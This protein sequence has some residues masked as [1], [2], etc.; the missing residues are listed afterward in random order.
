MSLSSPTPPD[1]TQTANTQ[2]QYNLSAGEASQAGSAV[3]QVNPYGSLTYTQTG[4]GPNGV[5]IYTAS[6][7]LSPAQQQL[8]NTLQGNQSTA[9]GQA[10]ALLAGANYGAQ[11]PSD[12]I[13]GATSGTTKALLGQETAYLNPFFNTQTSQLDTKLR[14]QG[15]APG[16]PGYDNA[17]RDLSQN[18]N[19]SVTGF[20]AQ[21]EPAAYQQA[22]QSYQ[23]PLQM[24]TQELGL[25]Q[26]GSVGQN[27]VQTPQLS[28]S[29]PDYSGLTEQ[30][31]AQQVAQHNA[32]MSGLFGLAGNVVGAAGKVVA[33]GK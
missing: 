33:G 6:S 17:M 5:P 31:Y 26:P 10:G 15:F 22:T 21:A 24:A 29:A 23:M 13:G 19:Q 32:M 28:V 9:G 3:N 25:S 4:T 27:L 11:N 20:L 18:Q 2:Q 30:N 1:P 7:Q 14:N 16:Q 8:L 12:V